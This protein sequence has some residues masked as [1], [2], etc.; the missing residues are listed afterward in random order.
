[1]VLAYSSKT[2]RYDPEARTLAKKLLMLVVLKDNNSV[3][4]STD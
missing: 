2:K 4:G 3:N 1:M